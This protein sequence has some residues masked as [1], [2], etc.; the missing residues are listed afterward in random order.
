MD[1]PAVRFWF[2]GEAFFLSQ[3]F[4]NFSLF[5]SPSRQDG[6]WGVGQLDE[7][8][9]RHAGQA[10]SKTT[11]NQRLPLPL[12]YMCIYRCPH[13]TV[14]AQLKIEIPD[15]Q[16]DRQLSRMQQPLKFCWSLSA[17]RASW[18]DFSLKIWNSTYKVLKLLRQPAEQCS[19]FSI[20]AS[21]CTA[22]SDWTRFAFF[23]SPFAIQ[24][25]YKSQI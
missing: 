12:L 23:M 8:S 1:L 14:T 19:L 13:R 6:G 7:L 25:R 18:R 20:S 9:M 24:F 22:V 3:F 4:S 11:G 15:P 10:L 21:V 17:A 5:F 2:P 16:N